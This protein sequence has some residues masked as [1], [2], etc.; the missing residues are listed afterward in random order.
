[1]VTISQSSKDCHHQSHLTGRHVREA[2]EHGGPQSSPGGLGPRRQ[3]GVGGGPQV[4]GV[5][6]LQPRAAGGHPAGVGVE[7]TVGVV[8]NAGVGWVIVRGGREEVA[9]V[10]LLPHLARLCWRGWLG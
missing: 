8:L 2:L 3:E 1:M 9:V 6:V 10:L 4:V 5:V 7:E